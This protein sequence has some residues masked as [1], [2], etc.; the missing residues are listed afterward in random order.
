MLE[1]PNL[2]DETIT[3]CLRESYGLADPQITFLPI[4]NDASAWAYGV[5]T[6]DGQRYFLKL[7]RGLVYTPAL[8]VPR[9]LRDSG[10]EQVVAPLPTASHDLSCLLNDF[11]L[12][13]YP[14]IDG[15]PG[16]YLYGNGWINIP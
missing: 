10:I 2:P 8:A 1:K 12:I 4:G 15:S 11:N 16:A 5:H 14:F 3:A 9:F 7:R 6:G 13:L